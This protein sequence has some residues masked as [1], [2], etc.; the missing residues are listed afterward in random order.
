[1]EEK[2]RH[3]S[4]LGDEAATETGVAAAVEDIP[5]PAPDPS[6]YADPAAARSYLPGAPRLGLNRLERL[7]S[8]PAALWA[9]TA[10]APQAHQI[11]SDPNLQSEPGRH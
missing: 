11:G 10:L 5:R 7:A 8:L 9:P 3:S 2:D 1:V 6:S 4:S